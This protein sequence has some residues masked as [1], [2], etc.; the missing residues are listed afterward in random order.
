MNRKKIVSILIAGTMLLSATAFAFSDID[1]HWAES[2]IKLLTADG[3]IKGYEDGTFR[4]DN[5]I[6]REEVAQLFSNFIG[7]KGLNAEV[8][9]DAK[10]RWST[11]A[12]QNLIS[13]GLLDGYPDGS[14]KPENRITRAEMANIAYK[15]LYTQESLYN[16]YINFSDVESDAWYYF[17]VTNAAGNAVVQG[18]LDGTFRPEDYITRA[19][20]ARIITNLKSPYP[21]GLEESDLEMPAKIKDYILNGQDDLPNA[22]KLLWLPEFLNNLS[23]IEIMNLYL[24]YMGEGNDTNDVIGFAKYVTENAPTKPGW[25]KIIEDKIEELFEEKVS[26][27]EHIERQYYNVYIEG[28]DTP[29]VTLNNAT[30]YFHG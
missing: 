20:A 18:Y 11:E 30:G 21:V 1:R 7:Q 2:D 23:D 19:E 4:P 28:R 9:D 13:R 17:A 24:D 16:Q 15:Y 6:T 3:I 8:P 5:S 12:I 22:D 27:F 10:N 14:F 25:E 26:H 29:F